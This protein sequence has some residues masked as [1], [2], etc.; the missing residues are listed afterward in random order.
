MNI[1]RCVVVTLIFLSGALSAEDKRSYFSLGDW[2]LG[3]KQ[4]LLLEQSGPF[5]NLVTV[6]KNEH[7]SANAKTIFSDETSVDLFFK[8]GK[9]YRLELS[10]YNGNSYEMAVASAKSI[11]SKFENEFGGAFLEGYTTSE[12]LK[13]DTFDQI[14]GQ[15]LVKSK[16][17][18]SKINTENSKGGEAYFNIFVSL[19]TEYEAKNNFLYGKFSYFGGSDVYVVTIYEDLKFNKD[20]VAPNMIHIGSKKSTN[21]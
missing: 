17:A 4:A 12:G 2:K 16:A 19:S 15:L 8:R 7:Y 9:L 6:K 13:P 1:L 5:K 21:E 3:E 14:I 18:M 11:I 20:H 10:L